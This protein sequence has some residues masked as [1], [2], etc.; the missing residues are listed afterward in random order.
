MPT[1]YVDKNGNPVYGVKSREEAEAERMS[2]YKK[3]GGKPTY[4]I[5]TGE[6]PPSM[7]D[8]QEYRYDQDRGRYMIFDKKR[9]EFLQGPAPKAEGDYDLPQ[10]R[11]EVMPV[12]QPRKEESGMQVLPTMNRSGDEM[13]D[14]EN[15]EVMQPRSAGP[16][17]VATPKLSGAQAVKTANKIKEAKDFLKVLSNREKSQSKYKR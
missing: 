13:W 5:A 16:Q 11:K 15:P 10:T 8:E 12:E 14:V 17:P 1:V 6:V 2:D 3:Y 7:R 4:E 9:G